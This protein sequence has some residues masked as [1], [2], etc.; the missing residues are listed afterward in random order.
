MAD[1][2][3]SAGLQETGVLKL[4]ACN[5]GRGQYLEK[6]GDELNKRNVKIGYLPGPEGL[7][8]DTRSNAK[9]FGKEVTVLTCRTA[10]VVQQTPPRVLRPGHSGRTSSKGMWMSGFEGHDT[11]HLPPHRTS[12]IRTC[13]SPHN[14]PLSH[15][16]PL[17]VR[18][19]MRFRVPMPPH[20][21][22]LP[23]SIEQTMVKPGLNGHLP[24][25]RRQRRR[26]CCWARR[27]RQTAG[28]LHRSSGLIGSTGTDTQARIS[29]RVTLAGHRSGR[30]RRS[31]VHPV[32]RR[33][34]VVI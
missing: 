17:R 32:A 27:V 13:R 20:T 31:V 11:T 9:L 18:A 24:A 4:Q 25:A 34:T 14:H 22:C 21:H 3:A 10:K 23:S 12:A 7:L 30:P 5:A 28:S 16:Y 8:I 2:L 26:C 33:K 6:L 15:E 19:E 1:R 29:R